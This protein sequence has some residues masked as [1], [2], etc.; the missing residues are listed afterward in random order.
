MTHEAKIYG[1]LRLRINYPIFCWLTPPVQNVI[2][3]HFTTLFSSSINNTSYCIATLALVVTSLGQGWP[4]ADENYEGELEG[5][6]YGVTIYAQGKFEMSL[7]I[8]TVIWSTLVRI[9]RVLCFA[10]HVSTNISVSII[11]IQK[12]AV[13]VSL[14]MQIETLLRRYTR[15]MHIFINFLALLKSPCFR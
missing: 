8:Y 12:R 1:K 5:R 4:T 3:F 15:T 9:L 14:K 7:P 10:L 2:K 13:L 6:R 11:R